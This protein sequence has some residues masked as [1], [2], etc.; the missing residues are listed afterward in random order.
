M[1]PYENRLNAE[2]FR[3]VALVAEVSADKQ[4]ALEA[5]LATKP[6][7]LAAEVAEAGISH[8]HLYLQSFDARNVL[9]IYFEMY[10]LD[11]ELAA[12]KLQAS[13]AWW[14]ELEPLLEA[15]PRANATDAPWQRAEF[16]NVIA[17]NTARERAIGQPAG[18]AAGLH[19]DQELWYRTLHQTN[20]PGVIDQMARSHYQNWT[21]FMLE[22]GDELMLFTHV[23]YMGKDQS[24]DD[25]RMAADPVTQRWWKHTEPCLFPLVQDGG[26]WA[27]MKEC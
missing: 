26:N 5:K 6:A 25:A 16:I 2:N 24:A 14:A 22:F 21:T 7:S 27:A 23:E 17:D 18:L 11:Q 4:A 3:R 13:S 20:W 12:Q 19:P 1:S 10:T 15:H 9:F 8:L